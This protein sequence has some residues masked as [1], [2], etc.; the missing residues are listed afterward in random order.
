MM[1]PDCSPPSD[2]S[3]RTI[4]SITYLSPTGHRTISM[5]LSRSAISRPILLMTVATMALPF[6]RPLAFRCR[7][8]ISSTASP[9]TIRPPAS[10]KIARSPSPSNATPMRQPCSRTARDRPSGC[11]EPQSRL[12]LRPSGAPLEDE[13]VEAQ[14]L[15]ELRRNG[16][17]RPIGR[18]DRDLRAGKALR[19]RKREARV[20]HV[21]VD[22]VGVVEARR[23]RGGHRPIRPRHDRL[24]FALERLGELLAL[25]REHLDAVVLERIVRRRNHDP[26]IERHRRRHVGDGR[27]RD[28]AGA[29]H[30][31]AFRARA[32]RQLLFDPRA[33]LARVAA[34][35]E[36]QRTLSF[37]PS[38]DGR[39]ARTSAAPRRATV[40]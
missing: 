26:G 29:R 38:I 25:A 11:V 7:A 9:S 17:R 2:R 19:I 34:D 14:V 32:A 28:D 6:S 31:R 21:L 16:R 1:W 24:D 39:M 22:D 8:H 18:V 35:H 13:Q 40:G 5:P 12:M 3:R 20:R 10:A 15:E 36:P 27:R 33:R 4:S 30:A 23:G 37:F